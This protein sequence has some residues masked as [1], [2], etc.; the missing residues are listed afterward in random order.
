MLFIK[1]GRE[2]VRIN[3]SYVIQAVLLGQKDMWDCDSK[4]NYEQK[5][6]A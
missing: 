2:N 3:G 5:V 4:P 1:C 6:I